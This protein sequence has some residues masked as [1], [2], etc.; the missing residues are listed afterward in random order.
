MTEHYYISTYGFVAL[1][2]SVLPFIV[3]I[4]NGSWLALVLTIGLLKY[5]L[6]LTR[7]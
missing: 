2:Y 6:I 3:F 1:L 5:S 7:K 4:G